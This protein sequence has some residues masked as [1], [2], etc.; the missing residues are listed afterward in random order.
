MRCNIIQLRSPS[1]A[2][3]LQQKT[4]CL[5]HARAKIRRGAAGAAKSLGLCP[6]PR[7]GTRPFD[8]L[9]KTLKNDFRVLCAKIIFLILYFCERVPRGYAPWRVWA[10]PKVLL[11]TQAFTGEGLMFEAYL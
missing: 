10:E 8:P 2:A 7:K 5:N 9:H 11:F 4:K 1:R 3:T 6:K